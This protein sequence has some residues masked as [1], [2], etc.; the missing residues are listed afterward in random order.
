M[1]R[2]LLVLLLGLAPVLHGQSPAATD[3]GTGPGASRLT[4]FFDCRAWCD[5]DYVREQVAFVDWVRERTAADVHLLVTSQ[6]AGAGGDQ[7]TMAFIGQRAAGGRA[8]TL[9]FTTAPTTTSDERRDLVARHVAA[10]LVPFVARTGNAAGLQITGIARAAGAP[11]PAPRHDPWN[12]W[13]FELGVSGRMNG[14]A[15]YRSKGLDGRLEADRVT[16]AWKTLLRF[17]YEYEDDKVIDERYDADGNLLESETFRNLQRNWEG[18]ALLVRS[19]GPHFSAGAQAEVESNTFRNL[20]RAVRTGPAVEYNFFPYSQATRR[21]LVVRYGVGI[22]ANRYVDTTIFDRTS[23]SLA[24][25]S[26]LLYYDTQQPWGSANARAEHRNYLRDASKRNSEVGGRLRVR[27]WGGFNVNAY[28]QYSWIR[29]QI[30]LRR[31]GGSQAD[32]LLRRRELLTG[33]Q[34]EAGLGLSYTFGSIFS[35]VVNPRF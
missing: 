14:E 5:Y 6:G 18:S 26:V 28:G 13:V 24:F 17:E 34:Y 19:L 25:Q 9:R 33:H 11:A 31:G 15:L 1:N 4:V 10:G 35:N 20:Q 30:A 23:E 2:L 32:V 22:E 21:E 27:L 16:E 3:G 29:D 12:F 7:Y 8:D